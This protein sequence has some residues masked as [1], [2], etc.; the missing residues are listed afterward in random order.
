MSS[1]GKLTT[2][3]YAIL[4]LLALRPWSTFELTK[5]MDRSLG[6]VW[7]RA[8]SK[9]Y[10]EP[11]KLVAHGLAQAEEDTVGRRARTV[12][13]ITGAGRRALA[14]WLAEPGAGPVL[15]F[16]GLLK[17]F[18]AEH[19]T[20]ADALASLAA[21]R[22]WAEERNRENLAAAEAYATGAGPFQERVAQTQLG[23]R[24]LT[25]FYAMVASWADWA[26]ALVEQWPDDPAQA[27]PDRAE[28]AETLRR[29]TW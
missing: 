9:L 15:E 14:A 17:V 3:S 12:Y 28:M 24:F 10:E 2:T 20:R 19:G 6:R 27:E 16:E 21:A 11:K 25:D 23:G 7:P 29:A 5:Q 1:P 22:R 18:F 8:A 26:T 13:S 4:S